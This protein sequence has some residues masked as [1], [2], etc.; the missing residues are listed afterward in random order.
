[1]RRAARQSPIHT[2][3]SVML[4]ALRARNYRLFFIGQGISLIGTWMTRVAMSWLVYRLTNS[5]L[6]LGVVGF[7]SQIP[8]FLL[9]PLTGV[10]ADRWNRHRILLVTQGLA[11]VHALVLAWLALSGRVTVPQL[12]ALSVVQGIV[13]AFDIPARQAFVVELVSRKD[14][15]GNA[16][17]LNSSIFN[18]ARLI[19]PSIAGVVIAALGEGSCFFIDG[20]SYL[21]VLA[22]LL[23]MRLPSRTSRRHNGPVLRELR[24]GLRYAFGS[25]PIRAI[26]L[27][28]GWVS[29]L[30]LPYTVLLPVVA[31]DILHGGAH[32]LGFLMAASGVGAVGGAMYLAS[33]KNVLGLGRVIAVSGAVFS[34]ALILFGWSRTHMSDLLLMTVIGFASIVQLA[35][36]NTVLQT[37]VEDDKRG[38][39]MSLY[40]TAVIGMAPFGSLLAGSLASRLGVPQTLMLGGMACLIATGL[41]ARKIPALR[42]AVRPV[43]TVRGIA[44]EVAQGIQAAAIFGTQVEE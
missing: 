41:F 12:I 19:G 44:P 11:M 25:P 8:T 27:F 6:L 15:V 39:V 16:I 17:A 3:L 32:T 2:S 28:V 4:R 42:A 29:L 30:G 33:R 31:K 14:D 38:R 7:A 5:A 22:A 40:A 20:V 9:T 23:A 1:M 26:L 34:C 37:M 36:G 13:N 35:S 21:A 18:A 10:L 24:D 43:A